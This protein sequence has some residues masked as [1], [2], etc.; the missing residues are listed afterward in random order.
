MTLSLFFFFMTKTTS[1]EG[2]KSSADQLIDTLRKAKDVPTNK[3]PYPLTEAQEIGWDARQYK[4]NMNSVKAAYRHQTEITSYM[5]AAWKHE[6]QQKQAQM[7][8]GGGK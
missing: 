5:D 8:G 7:Q 1:G 4:R 2:E 3:Y 6:E